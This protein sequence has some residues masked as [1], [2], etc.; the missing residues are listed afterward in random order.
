VRD[1]HGQKMSKTKGNVIDPLEAIDE[2]GA[3]AVRFALAIFASPGANIPLAKS[4]IAG[5]RAFATKL[6]NAARFTLSQL[7][8]GPRAE[9]LEGRRLG[10]PERWILSRLHGTATE[11][12]RQLEQFRFDEAAQAVYAFLWHELCD[13]YLEMS[14]PVLSGREGTDEDRETVRAVLHETLRDALCLLHPF[15]PFVTEEIW[16]K[17][18]NA[19]GTLIVAPYP[20]GRPERRD[21][22]AERVVTALRAIVTR[23]RS[24]RSERAAGPTE[25]VDL[26]IDPESPQGGLL[27]R[28]RELTSLLTSLARLSTLRFSSEAG[29]GAQD[30]I[31]GV[32]LEL[33]FPKK[34]AGVNREQV[35]RKLADVDEEISSVG[36]KLRNPQFLEKAPPEIVEK[37][38]RRLVELEERRAALGS[39]L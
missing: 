28:I 27:P 20:L 5:Y 24:F 38:R 29:S 16:E 23:V 11:V 21:L 14:K 25:P 6:W 31:E 19:P 32:A 26:R 37:M 15:M 9:S 35:A 36:A 2:F 13:G 12:N 30:V 22:E 34:A 4:R 39:G 3:D 18:T 10:L 8:A 7:E 33:S 1:E 17:L